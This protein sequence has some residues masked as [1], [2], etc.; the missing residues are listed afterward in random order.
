MW[1]WCAAALYAPQNLAPSGGINVQRDVNHASA[2]PEKIDQRSE[3]LICAVVCNA[4]G[5]SMG[6]Q[7]KV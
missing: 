5:R 6:S 1:E 4:R 2:L 3:R 7:N